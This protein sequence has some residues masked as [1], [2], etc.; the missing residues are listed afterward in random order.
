MNY[1]I[2]EHND[3]YVAI[4]FTSQA[5]DEARSY[6]DQQKMNNAIERSKG[7]E[8]IERGENAVTKNVVDLHNYPGS[9]MGILYFSFGGRDHCASAAFCGH[10]Q[11]ILTASRH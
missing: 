9:A 7:E 2:S 8:L 5:L 3:R 6:W 10:E 11:I 1:T 4:T